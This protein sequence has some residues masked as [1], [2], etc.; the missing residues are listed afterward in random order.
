MSPVLHTVMIVAL[1]NCILHSVY[2]FAHTVTETSQR[3][4]K[5]ILHVV[6]WNM[7]FIIEHNFEEVCI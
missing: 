1:L 4:I 5:I 3:K 2:N 6:Y 7:E